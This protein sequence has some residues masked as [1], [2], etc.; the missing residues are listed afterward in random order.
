MTQ[1]QL[2]DPSQITKGLK[3]GDALNQTLLTL[4][5]RY[6]KNVY[7]SMSK[8]IAAYTSDVILH[9]VIGDPKKS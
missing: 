9:G 5:I 6:K 7:R 8:E 2:A 3:Q 1:T 4:G